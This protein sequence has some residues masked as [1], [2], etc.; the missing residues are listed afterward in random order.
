MRS[1][2]AVVL[3]GLL[4]SSALAQSPES[5]ADLRWTAPETSDARFVI[6]PGHRAFVGG[7]NVPGVE[8]WTY[9]LQLVRDYWISFRV[10]GDTSETDGRSAL[11]NIEQTPTAATREYEA[12]GIAVREHIVVPV[13]VPAA[14]IS[15]PVE[16]GRTVCATAPHRHRDAGQFRESRT[17][18]GADYARAGM[19]LQSTA[20]LRT[21]GRVRAVARLPAAAVRVVFRGRRS[22]CSRRTP[23]RRSVRARA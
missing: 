3:L 23:P 9:P 12:P 17:A 19:G 16:S 7:Y 1:C 21:G 15:Y 6:V 14:T 4:A 20:R 2:R 18:L 10:E 22:R 5:L 8:V 13:D 11:R